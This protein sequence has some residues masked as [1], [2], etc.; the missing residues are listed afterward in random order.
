[1]IDVDYIYCEKCGKIVFID[2]VHTL[3]GSELCVECYEVE[4][5]S[6]D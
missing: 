6:E 1:M 3:Y 2:Q 5:E 4:V